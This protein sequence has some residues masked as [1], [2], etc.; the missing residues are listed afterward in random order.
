MWQDLGIIDIK[1]WSLQLFINRAK[2]KTFGGQ[3]A[4]G[5]VVVSAAPIPTYYIEREQYHIT[6]E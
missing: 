3:A 5:E 1:V 4:N 2:Q 6:D